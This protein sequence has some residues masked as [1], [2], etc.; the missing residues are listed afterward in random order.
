MKRYTIEKKI[1]QKRGELE[2]VKKFV[3]TNKY[4]S[5]DALR[6]ALA[7]M[8]TLEHEITVLKH[9]LYL[10]RRAERVERNVNL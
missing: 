1:A 10:A 7:N 8:E 5:G 3:Y 6:E 9:E 2:K 4:A